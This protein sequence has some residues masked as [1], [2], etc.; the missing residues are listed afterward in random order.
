MPPVCTLCQQPLAPAELPR[1][2]RI[3]LAEDRALYFHAPCWLQ[4]AQRDLPELPVSADPARLA[5]SG[6]T[7]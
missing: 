7:R 6:A 1:A 4:A 2:L 5:L 3:L